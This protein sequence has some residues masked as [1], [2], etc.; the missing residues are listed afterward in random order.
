VEFYDTFRPRG[1]GFCAGLACHGKNA[2][3]RRSMVLGSTVRFQIGVQ[4][5]DN[6]A[7]GRITNEFCAADG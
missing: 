5:F 7:F 1:G 6:E 3:M 4:R 2:A